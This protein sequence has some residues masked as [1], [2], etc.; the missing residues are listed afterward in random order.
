MELAPLRPQLRS[1]QLVCSPPPPSTKASEV[2]PQPLTSPS[3][4]SSPTSPH[5]PSKNKGGQQR[6]YLVGLILCIIVA[7]LSYVLIEVRPLLWPFTIYGWLICITFHIFFILFMVA[8]YR[9]ATTDPGRVPPEWGFKQGDRKKQRRYCKICNVW[10]PDRCH[11]CSA[12]NRCVLNMDHHCPWLNTCVGF[13]NRR[14]FI[15]LLIYA[16]I[17]CLFV[18]VHGVFYI[19]TAGISVWNPQT[20]S[21]HS[22]GPSNRSMTH[23]PTLDSDRQFHS[24]HNSNVV[25]N[26]T[27][28]LNNDDQTHKDEID[29]VDESPHLSSHHEKVDG[30]HGGDEVMGRIYFVV[31]D[32]A[33]IYQGGEADE[34]YRYHLQRNNG[35]DSPD[36]PLS[37]PSPHDIS[38]IHSLSKSEKSD[39]YRYEHRGAPINEAPSVRGVIEEVITVIDIVLVC[40]IE[41]FCLMLTCALVPFLK[42]HLQLVTMNS[43][44]IES[45]DRD[46]SPRKYDLGTAELNCK[47]VFG[48]SSSCW[49]CPLTTKGALPVGDGVNWT[50]HY[51]ALTQN[52]EGLNVEAAAFGF[53]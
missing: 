49:G 6:V 37:P 5:S 23:N 32:E 39:L 36:S 45:L 43:T 8:F 26:L 47:Q 29:D 18:S 24:D 10:K 33:L 1:E 52:G 40:V 44:T 4:T 31:D 38:D 25:R 7:Y 28:D 17:S 22:L 15:Q 13:N 21:P 48:T 51:N 9:S 34:A 30:K 3:S 11:H 19:V 2:T 46:V 27:F 14:F 16:L 12:C 42:F 50:Q 53:V 20:E 35:E 41:C